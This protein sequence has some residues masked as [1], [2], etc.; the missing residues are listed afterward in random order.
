MMGQMRPVAGRANVIGNSN[1][2]GKNDEFGNYVANKNVDLPFLKKL[3]NFISSNPAIGGWLKKFRDKVLYNFLAWRYGRHDDWVFM[4]YGYRPNKCEK[5]F[6][7]EKK[8][9]ADRYCIEMYRL[10]TKHIPLENKMLLEVGCGR[11]GGASFLAR[12]FKPK[13][14][15]AIDLAKKAIAFC[16]K[17]HRGIPN[18]EFE[19]GDAEKLRFY[20]YSFD[21]VINIESV[22]GYGN[23]HKFLSE[24]ERVLMVNGY[25]FCTTFM[26]PHE[27]DS[28]AMAIKETGF[29]I[30]DIT[31]LT[32]NVVGALDADNN[33][34]KTLIDKRVDKKL[35]KVF[36]E[37]AGLKGSE[38]Y[39][40]FASGKMLYHAFLCQKI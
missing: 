30:V 12:Y 27:L 36:Y 7:L 10:I 1:N 8:D 38:H 37:F 3:D 21:A 23:V 2:I 31:D 29:N 26:A 5:T 13:K 40:N 20:D 6:S 4:N 9:A 11:G 16:R 33:R 17:N 19:I 34:K 14:L 22:Q 39:N 32:P 15:I 25:F 35:L 18:L 28:F 24:V